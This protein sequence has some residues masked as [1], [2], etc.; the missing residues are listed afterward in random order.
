MGVDFN[1]PVLEAQFPLKLAF[2][3]GLE[4]LIHRI[5]DLSHVPGVLGWRHQ[6]DSLHACRHERPRDKA[7]VRFDRFA[8]ELRSLA[9]NHHREAAIRAE[10]IEVRAFRAYLSVREILQKLDELVDFL[11]N[12]CVFPTTEDFVAQEI[13]LL[14]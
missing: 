2:E 11:N 12:D 14:R 6:V 7:H 8:E 3:I 9:N 1:L 10:K 13:Q 5:G 4:V